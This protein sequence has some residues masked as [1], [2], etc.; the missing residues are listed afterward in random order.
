MISRN[1]KHDP[2]MPGKFKP[3][4][5]IRVVGGSSRQW[6]KNVPLVVLGY[7]WP[8]DPFV[9]DLDGNDPSLDD[10]TNHARDTDCVLDVF[11]TEARRANGL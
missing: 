8:N 1:F 6:L 11:L 4:D 7:Q 3:G 5:I 9:L 10:W 2:A